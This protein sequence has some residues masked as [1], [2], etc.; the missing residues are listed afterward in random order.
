[1][2]KSGL[3]MR[4][5]RGSYRMRMLVCRRSSWK[6]ETE[7]GT[8]RVTRIAPAW[9]WILSVLICQSGVLIGAFAGC[10]GPKATPMSPAGEAASH[11]VPS[12]SASIDEREPPRLLITAWLE[13]MRE[14]VAQIH[15]VYENAGAQ[16]RVDEAAFV[17][18]QQAGARPLVGPLERLADKLWAAGL[19]RV[20]P[21]VRKLAEL[22]RWGDEEFELA[23]AFSEYVA[24][25]PIGPRVHVTGTSQRDDVLQVHQYLAWLDGSLRDDAFVASMVVSAGVGPF[26]PIPVDGGAMHDYSERL[27]MPCGVEIRIGDPVGSENAPRL[28]AVANDGSVAW[29]CSLPG[30]VGS[31][32][33]DGEPMRTEWG[34]RLPLRNYDELAFFYVTLSCSPLCYFVPR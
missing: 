22:E 7:L 12:L 3:V 5:R 34:W 11:A 18:A 26:S 1:V 10:V 32:A 9:I 25:G 23:Q 4:D 6:G 30:I 13:E 14:L 28:Q 19:L 20:L 24:L 8:S 21:N 29:T 15:D 31:V 27:A 33:L 17:E 16:E 2:S